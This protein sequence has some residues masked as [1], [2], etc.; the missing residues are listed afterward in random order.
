MPLHCS[1]T[2]LY[3]QAVTSI[4]LPHLDLSW[5]EYVE[6]VYNQHN[7]SISSEYM[8]TSVFNDSN[9]I[10]VNFTVSSTSSLLDLPSLKIIFV[11]II[12]MV[13]TMMIKMMMMR[14]MM[15]FFM[16]IIIILIIVMAECLCTK[17]C[18]YINSNPYVVVITIT[19]LIYLSVLLGNNSF[20]Q[21]TR[22]S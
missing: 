18:I 12:M 17:E 4:E 2:P 21:V 13:T 10:I 5:R 22:V 1:P 7:Q 20:M 8:H 11:I 14:M 9:L 16:I 15:F 19:L 6:E 3:H